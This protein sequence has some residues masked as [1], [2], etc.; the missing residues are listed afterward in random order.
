LHGPTV[1]PK[2]L[3]PPNPIPAAPAAP[4]V[5]IPFKYY[6]FVKPGSKGETNRGFFLDGD[7]VIVASEGELLKQRYLVVALTPNSARMEDT[8]LKQGQT[9]PLVPEATP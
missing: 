8:Q 3:P 4:V 1:I 9:L 5:N 7:N 6:G 2:P